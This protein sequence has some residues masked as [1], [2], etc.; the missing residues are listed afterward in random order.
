MIKILGKDAFGSMLVCFVNTV[1]NMTGIA[2]HFVRE[3]KGIKV[4]ELALF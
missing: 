4:M 1:E 3:D 2:T